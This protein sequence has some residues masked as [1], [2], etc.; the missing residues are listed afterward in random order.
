MAPPGLSVV[1]APG[2]GPLFERLAATLE[3]AP[4]P[5]LQRETVVVSRNAGLRAWLTHALAERV[6]CAASLDLPAVVGLVD[7][8]AGTRQGDQ[9]FEAGPLAWRLAPILEALDGDPV[10]APLRSYL[11]KTGQT[12]PLAS[13][14]ARLFDDYQVYRPDVLAAW[15]EGAD[16]IPD[17]AHGAWQAALWRALLADGLEH[18]GLL[19]D[20]LRAQLDRPAPRLALPPRISVFGGLVLPPVYAGMLAALARHVPV[21][22][23]AVTPGH[24]P[25]TE[26]HAHP[27]LRALAGRTRDFWSVQAELGAPA[28]ERLA[29]QPEVG[30]GRASPPPVQEGLGVVDESSTAS[31]PAADG[32]GGSFPSPRRGEAGRGGDRPAPTDVC[33]P[34]QPSPGGGGGPRTAAAAPPTALAQ[35]RAALGADAPPAAPVPLDAADRSV[36][37]HDCHSP[38]RELEALRD[39]LLDAFADVPGLRPSD[40]LVVVPDLAVYAPLVDAVFEAE[41]ATGDGGGAVVRLPVHVVNHPHA[42]ALRVVEA[43]RKALRMHDG[44]V[45]ASE[46]LDLLGYPVV[47][48]AAG[49]REDELP[50]LRAWVKEAGVCWGLT[51][52]RKERFGLPADDLHT[53]RYGLDRLLLGVMTGGAGENAA[54]ETAAGGAEGGAGLVLG[55]A[56][57]DAAGLDGADLL[58]RFCEWAEALFSALGAIDRPAPL[59]EW[60]GHLLRF[61]DGVFAAEAEEE[62]EAVVFLRGLA[63]DLAGLDEL[64]SS[65]GSD[66]PFRVVRAHLDGA[67]GSFEQREAVLTGRIT[68]ADP[69]V[70]RHAP[71]RVV[72]FLGLGD[73][74]WPRPETPAGFDLLAQHPHPGDASPRATE[75][76]LF[77]DA[78]LAAGDRLVLSYVGRSEKDNAERAASV[79]LDAFLDACDLH[80]GPAGREQFVVRHRLQPFAESYFDRAGPTSY[81]GQHLVARA[82]AAPPRPYHDGGPLPDEDDAGE[83]TLADLAAAWTNPSQF[84]VR[85]RLKVSLDLEE[86]AV[87]DD[88]P[89]T[90][91][92]LERWRVREAVVEGALGGLSDTDLEALLLR[93]GLLP[94]GAPGAALLRRIR[95]EAA[96]VVDAV[97]AWGPTEPRAVEVDVAGTRVVGTVPHLGERGALRYRAGAVRPRHLV[98]SWLDHLAL[99]AVEGGAGRSCTVGID[100]TAHFESVPAHEARALLGALAKGYHQARAGRLPV[101]ERASHAYADKLS[102][103]D[104]ADY[105]GRVVEGR[106]SRSF[107]PA[108]GAVI[109]ARKAFDPWGDARGDRDDAY[110]ALAT[111]GRDP[112]ERE[113]PFAKWSLALWAPLLH[114]RREGVPS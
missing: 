2:L 110:V 90:L 102:S 19:L 80:W 30:A 81:A 53:W 60:P 20:R 28:P 8:L 27:L 62:V 112:F 109:A 23:Y 40:V 111:R 101:Y 77:V 71:F 98:A 5:P 104:L 9:P 32:R 65:P 26:P 13:R 46:L 74:V 17:F 49:I 93:G 12:M 107:R 108:T 82:Q 47:R 50:R 4:L 1:T 48:Q 16:P 33:P 76:Q 15:A 36:R 113:E 10:T 78:V 55:H 11:D 105:A 59:A 75:K 25:T 56:A 51:G 22:V 94:G 96:P 43:F 72:A 18:R 91:G 106:R 38:R 95:A 64:A 67:A 21:T 41:S 68:V 79:C 63:A 58:G 31:Q 66:V 92:G 97:R 99:C 87:R 37:V 114:A 39:A 73:G 88:E 29:A 85:R 24:E 54:A 45:T 89:V 69:L 57:C 35:L 34:P 84:A 70:L 14:L 100:G 44:R 6:G 103:R 3:A 7:R 42:P 52:E 86:D 61:L 83:V